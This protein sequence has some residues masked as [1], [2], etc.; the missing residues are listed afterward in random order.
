VLQYQSSPNL[1]GNFGS[2][3]GW[4]SH[5]GFQI[6][7]TSST[8]T[9]A[10]IL[11]FGNDGIVV[12]PQAF[13]PG[14]TAADSYVIPFAAGN[15]SGWDQKVDIRTFTDVNGK[16]I[17]LNGD[18]IADFVGMGP[19]GLVYADGDMNG[20]GG[21][22]ELGPLKTAHIDGDN[23]NL[24]EAQG[25]TDTTTLRDIVYDSKTG[26]D[27][28]IAFGAAGVYV[29]M[30]QDPATHSGEPFGKLYLAMADFGS[31]QGWSVGKTPRLIGDVTGDGI[32]DIV[33]FGDSSTFVA[34]GSRDSSSNL[35]FKLDP[36]KTIGDFG[37]A[38]GWSGSTQQTVRALGT[39][40][41]TGSAHSDLILSGASNTQ[42]W[43]FT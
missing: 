16:P 43:H 12:G 42:V 11:G 30:G 4:T 9:S 36:N 10:S 38:E 17:D 3:Q 22:Y 2:Q 6:L 35:Q 24:G 40:A 13:A 27:D 8:D 21:T 15:N 41:G 18:G 5:N 39:V 32:I 33:G 34:V 19:T 31:D 14:A 28:V 29:S 26:Y 20:S 1:Y 37:A 25:W 7:K 23:S